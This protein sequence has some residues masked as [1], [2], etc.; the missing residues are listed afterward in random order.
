MTRSRITFLSHTAAPGGGEL[1]LSRYLRATSLDAELVTMAGGDVWKGLTC[2]VAIAPSLR[3]VRHVLRQGRGP[4]VANSMRAALY[5]ALVSPRSRPLVY[6][7]RDGLVDSAMSASAV[8]VTKMIT[9]RRVSHYIA[10]STYTA[11]TVRQALGAGDD[12]ID[13]VYSISGIGEQDALGPPR[14]N[15][16]TPVRLLYLGRISPWKAPD[17]AVRVLGELRRSG[18]RA[19][20]TIAGDA[21]FG[22]EQYRA[23]LARLVSEEPTATMI[24]HV[25]DVASLL[26][27]HD[28]LLHCSVRPEPFGQVIVQSLAAGVPVVAPG[29]GGPSDLLQGSPVSTSYPIG[30]VAGMTTAVRRAIDHYPSLSL[31]AVSRALEFVDGKLVRAADE[32]LGRLLSSASDR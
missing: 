24:G 7:V 9:A 25:D 8:A 4:V 13:V 31:W 2:P 26:K 15:P 18:V 6:W 3:Q 19:T 5:A 29:Q 11:A 23:D 17:I 28:V 20:L 22:E 12:Q 30:D 21:L 27:E 10:N 1:A 14:R 16:R 32:A